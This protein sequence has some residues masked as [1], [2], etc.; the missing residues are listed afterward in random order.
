VGESLQS[1]M[2]KSA[3]EIIDRAGADKIQKGEGLFARIK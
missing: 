3:K 2:P 1:F